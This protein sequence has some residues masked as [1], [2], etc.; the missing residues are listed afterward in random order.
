MVQIALEDFYVSLTERE[1]AC[2]GNCLSLLNKNSF[3]HSVVDLVCFLGNSLLTLLC[4]NRSMRP[5][6]F[7]LGQPVISGGQIGAKF[8]VFEYSS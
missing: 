4:L 8:C 3:C 2:S 5:A 1:Q 6:E 7:K